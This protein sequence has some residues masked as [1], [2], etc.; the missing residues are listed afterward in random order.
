MK[1]TKPLPC[2]CGHDN[3]HIK[4]AGC[5]REGCYCLKYRSVKDSHTLSPYSHKGKCIPLKDL[6]AM[7]EEAYNEAR[8]TPS[9]ESQLFMVV[10]LFERKL[11]ALEKG[12]V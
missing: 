6:R 7:W 11:R 5:T 1:P 12:E 3:L 2:I 9:K 8:H 10:Q 4:P